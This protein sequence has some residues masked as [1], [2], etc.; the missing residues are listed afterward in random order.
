MEAATRKN[1][2]LRR[3]TQ[4]V[5]VV[6]D[7]ETDDEHARVLGQHRC[8]VEDSVEYIDTDGGIRQAPADCVT[9]RKVTF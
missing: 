9:V 8:D 2:E 5:F 6:I 7:L 1:D 4:H 3:A